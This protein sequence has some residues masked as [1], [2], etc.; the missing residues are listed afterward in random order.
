MKI[1]KELKKI[2][3]T[4]TFLLIV[5]AILA[6]TCI[7][8]FPHAQAQTITMSNPGGIAQRDII[9]YE[10]DGTMAGFYNSTSVITLN[11]SR[12]YIFTMKPISSNLLDD[13]KDWVENTAFPWLRTNALVLIVCATIIGLA[14]RRR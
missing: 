6:F 1:K 14:L 3:K 2:R 13:P 12:D 9:V 11:S 10:A 8:C 7:L 4:Q 5:F